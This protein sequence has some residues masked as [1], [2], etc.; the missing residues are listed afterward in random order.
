MILQ[1]LLTNKAELFPENKLDFKSDCKLR[2]KLGI[3]P[4]SKDIHLGHS[5]LFNKL[6]QFQDAGHTAILILGDFTAKIGDPTGKSATR[7]QLSQEQVDENL[8]TYLEQLGLGKSPE[9][10]V[11][12]FEKP[13]RLEIYRNSQWLS[14]L[15]LT[16][17]IQLM[18]KTTVGQ[19]LAKED[20]ST[21][22]SRGNPISLHEFLYPL[23][24]GYDSVITRADIELGGTDQKFN[25]GIGRDLQK[26]YGQKPQYGLLL[27]ILSGIDGVHKMSKSLGNTI[28]LSEPAIDMYS[29]LEKIPDRLVDQYILLLTDKSLSAFPSDPREKQKAMA[30]TIT[31][32]YHGEQEA[33]LA[34]E[35]ATTMILRTETTH[36]I[37]GIPELSL[38]NLTFPI[39]AFYLLSFFNLCK[40]SNEAKMLIKN[41]GVKLNS[42]KLTDSSLLFNSPEELSNVILQVGKKTIRK[43]VP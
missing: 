21:R 36:R 32:L 6:R 15:D 25:V 14:D 17:L 27:P 40:S 35:N 19:M 41:G 43:L 30:F 4:T 7:V 5:V 8:E 22:Y 16:T 24:Q 23:L 29:K 3:D 9:E 12:D 10:S 37:D 26:H 1:E 33:L 39:K 28:G 42:V 34:Q 38:S 2:I 13:E 20:F 18:A 31:S 11:L